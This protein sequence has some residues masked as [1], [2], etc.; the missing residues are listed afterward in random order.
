MSD[1]ISKLSSYNLFNYLFPGVIFV[2]F[3]EMT[4][5]YSLIQKD[6]FIGFFVYYF[7]GL[8]ISRFGSIFIEP[9]LK[10]I[11]VL[12][13]SE[14]NDFVSASKSDSKVETLSEANNMYRTLCALFVLLIFVKIYEKLEVY[15]SFILEYRGIILIITFLL[16]FVF[17]YSKQTR[18]IKK[19]VDAN[20]AK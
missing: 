12:R 9:T 11:G 1:I 2:V 7:L 4:T 19:R 10:K 14:Y 16:V 5:G 20:N 17:S 13:F 3:V 15:F 6:I 8:I 18:Y